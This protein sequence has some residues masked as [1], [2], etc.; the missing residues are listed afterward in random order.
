MAQAR[1][2]PGLG[3]VELAVLSVFAREGLAGVA[4]W[5]IVER[6]CGGREEQC[7]VAVTK[8][9]SRLRRRGLAYKKKY[10]GDVFYYLTR[11]GKELLVSLCPG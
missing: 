7:R 10:K 11:D 1:R 5:T 3:P 2:W 8:A 9:L 6:V 4:Y